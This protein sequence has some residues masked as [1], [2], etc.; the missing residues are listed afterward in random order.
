[1]KFNGSKFQCI[2]YGQNEDLKNDT[3]YFT[4]NM[5]GVIDQFSNLRDLGVILSD[6]AKF[7]HHIEKVVLKVRQKSGWIFRTFYSRSINILKQLWK[8]VVQCHID[9]CSQLY[10][11][12]QTKGMM[13]I[14][15]LFY[16]FTSRI[17]ELKYENYWRR[18]DLLKMYSQERRMERY[19]VIYM[20]KILEGYAPNCGVKTTEESARLGRRCEIP[21][22]AK[23]GRMAIQTL[24]E[25]SFQVNGARLFNCI[26][27]KIRSIKQDQDLFKLELDKFLSS[28]PDQPRLG[29]LVPE[30]VCRV[31]ARQSNSLLAWTQGT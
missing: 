14:E 30:A 18:L 4:A 26:P 22:L 1:M 27:L 8:T 23:N 12:S 31:T 13:A 10:K 2:R 29:S 17:P 6:D 21:K 25:Q 3:V 5:E 28:I 15:K 16:D 24:R 7:D 20:W 11:P 19:R 9:Y